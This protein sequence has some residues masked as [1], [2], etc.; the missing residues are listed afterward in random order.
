MTKTWCRINAATK[1]APPEIFIY[2]VIGSWFRDTD[3]ATIAQ[4]IKD[5][6]ADE[7]R[8]RINSPGGDA[9][10]GIAIFNALRANDARV[11]VVVDGLAASAASVIAM[12]GDVIVMGPGSQL[13]IHEPWL[14]TEGSAGDLRKDADRLDK[15]AT[16]ITSI[17][18]AR[19]GGDV[20]QWRELVADETWF[21]ADE[22]IDAGLADRVDSSAA[23]DARARAGAWSM[24]NFRF[25][26]REHAP[27]PRIP[28]AEAVEVPERKGGV[29]PTLMEDLRQRLGTAEDADEKTVL[30][31][32]D[33]A[34][35]E[36]AGDGAGGISLDVVATGGGG[37][38]GGAVVGKLDLAAEMEKR[39]MVAVDSETLE[40]LR[41][42]AEAGA[43]AR[44]R[45]E[46]AEREALVDAKIQSG[47]V[48]PARRDHWIAAFAGDP[49]GVR[50]ALAAMPDGLIPLAEIGHAGEPEEPAA[51][52]RESAEYKSWEC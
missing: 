32:L 11:T 9:F 4:Q 3:A 42:G 23:P 10:D 51:D 29:M 18:A 13:M 24:K 5:L 33:E 49:E 30:A 48:P 15:L 16:S 47:A 34:L 6:D 43:A 1:D 17:Y 12:A 44:A 40:Q 46:Q 45:Q 38:G 25:A 35:A 7:L 36:Q 39:G 52:I 14:F 26:G 37:G 8:V 21:T 31:A 50:E 28:S 2:D 22:A 19:A 41:A 27:A 20:D